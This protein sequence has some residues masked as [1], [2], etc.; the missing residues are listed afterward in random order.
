MNRNRKELVVA[1]LLF[2][3]VP[4][5]FAYLSLTGF[6]PRVSVPADVRDKLDGPLIDNIEAGWRYLPHDCTV[7]CGTTDN[8]YTVI[9]T[10]GNESVD[11][12]WESD[13]SFQSFRTADQIFSLARMDEV[14]SIELTDR[15]CYSP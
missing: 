10:I 1:F 9:D 2:L 4:F 3:I 12:I 11:S 14:R 7:R 13:S 8:M 15:S 6:N 5:S